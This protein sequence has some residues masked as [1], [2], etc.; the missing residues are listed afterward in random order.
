MRLFLSFFLT[1]SVLS[2]LA[3]CSG[4]SE[5][6]SVS[7]EKVHDH[8]KHMHDVIEASDF[9]EQIPAVKL[10]INED[11]MSGWNLQ[12]V[13]DNFSFAPEQ[14]NQDANANEGHAHIFVNDYKFHRVYSHWLH[15]KKLTPG[16]HT[17]RVTL[18]AN[19]HSEWSHNGRVISAQVSI[20][21]E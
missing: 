1:A 13:T 15:L 5:P 16:E 10:V 19:D 7:V 14:V 6:S 9:G 21:Q 3:G 2:L 11:S 18:N 20:I 4:D 17:I 12:I 8:S